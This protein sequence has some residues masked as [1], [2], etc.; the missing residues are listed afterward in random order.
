M[1]LCNGSTGGKTGHAEGPTRWTPILP[2]LLGPLQGQTLRSNG[3]VWGW[4][5]DLETPQASLDGLG[6]VP[7][8]AGQYGWPIITEQGVK[9]GDIPLPTFFNLVIEVPLQQVP[10]L[11]PDGCRGHTNPKTPG[12]RAL[13]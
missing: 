5:K 8:K 13:H 11:W 7:K 1:Q 9:Q 3:S 4:T 2:S 6:V 10:A 12:F